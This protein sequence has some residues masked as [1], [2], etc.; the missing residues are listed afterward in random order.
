M[1]EPIKKWGGKR[2]GAGRPKTI[3]R[4]VQDAID[5][6]DG[7]RLYQ[8][9]TQWSEGE[10]VICPHCLKNTGQY[11]GNNVALESVKE[12]LNRKYG[13][14]IARSEIDITTNIRLTADQV[15]LLIERY[16]I[17]QRALLPQGITV[18]TE[19]VS[20]V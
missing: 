5:E 10:P 11:T 8:L 7:A 17:S 18:D 16:Q 1:A 12:L 20:V 19:A 14:S 9:L 3:R 4:Q 13:K 2:P 15:D 6:V